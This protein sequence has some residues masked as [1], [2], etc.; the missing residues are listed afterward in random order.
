MLLNLIFT[1]HVIDL[2]KFKNKYCCIMQNSFINIV[3]DNRSYNEKNTNI[4]H[5]IIV[6]G[7]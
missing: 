3:L 1:Y 5:I 2:I 6:N 7:M 4:Y